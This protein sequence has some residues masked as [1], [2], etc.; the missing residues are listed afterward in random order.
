MASKNQMTGMLGVYLVA[1]ELCRRNFIVS[2]T[3]RSAAGADLLVTD[4]ECRFAW[5][6]QVKTNRYPANFWLL[7]AK[8]ATIES[9]SHM[10][11]FVNIGDVNRP[12]EFIVVP[13]S[14]VAKHVDAETSSTGSKWYSFYK[15]NRITEGAGW[16]LFDSFIPDE[17]A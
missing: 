14:H 13:S 5:S 16:E 12:D 17:K 3:S 2:P 10:Y 11:V 15:S 7:G 1:A 8:A 4:Q 6:V 9:K